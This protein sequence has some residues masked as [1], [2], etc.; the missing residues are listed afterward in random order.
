M[1]ELLER[2][3]GMAHYEVD[4]C[5]PRRSD[6][7]S[8]SRVP[9]DPSRTRQVPPLGRSR[10]DKLSPGCATTSKMMPATIAGFTGD[11]RC[12]GLFRSLNSAEVL[13]ACCTEC[14]GGE[15]PVYECTQSSR[16]TGRCNASACESDHM[17]AWLL[18]TTRPLTAAPP[19][20][21][22]GRILMA[23]PST[24]TISVSAPRTLRRTSA[25]STAEI[26]ARIEAMYADD[27]RPDT[28]T[29]R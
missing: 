20:S 6:D 16:G 5:P 10:S 24:P 13:L 28:P 4:R 26:K 11:R 29:A 25:M 19:Q 18:E 3:C 12:P 27:R 14:R 7:R 2:C 21:D 23:T 17:C 1:I 15:G 8:G 22:E 9:A